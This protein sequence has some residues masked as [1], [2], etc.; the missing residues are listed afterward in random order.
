MIVTEIYNGQ[1]L[2]NQLW[3]YVVTRVIAL[4]RGYSYGI[5]NHNKFKGLDFLNLDFGNEVVGGSGHEG[6]DPYTLPNGIKYYYKE[7]EIQ[8]PIS[9]ADIRIYDKNLV[10]VPDNTKIDGVMQD[11]QYILHRKNEIRGWLQVKKEYDCYDYSDENICVIN[12]RGGEFARHSE[13]FLTKKY[14][15]DAIA[16]M[17][18]INKNF[19][20]VVIT[21]D[22]STA[23]TFFPD[24]DVMH[25]NIGKD[26]SIIKNAYY[27]ILSNSSFAW[28]PAWLSETLKYCI[29]PKYF[30]RHNIS[31][32]YWSLGYNITSDWHYQDRDGK[33][34]EY[35]ECIKE[36]Q[37]YIASHKDYFPESDEVNYNFVPNT[38]TKYFI[39]RTIFY[40][41][42]VFEVINRHLKI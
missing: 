19:K 12:F 40:T 39:K 41:K 2:G 4:D 17:L 29:A 16:N 25:F 15:G 1:G 33:L 21:D 5:K 6:E 24:Y 3:C 14:W 28:F 7:R 31:D 42:K 26:Y 36:F 9:K 27:L 20:F 38:K 35:D 34:F 8:H 32:G 11:E 37:N 10:N 22:V 18:K 30:G 23:R 13:V